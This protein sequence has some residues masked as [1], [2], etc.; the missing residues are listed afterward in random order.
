[1]PKA[2]SEEFEDQMG[3]VL[4]YF[5]NKWCL[6]FSCSFFWIQF[7]NFIRNLHVSSFVI[8]KLPINSSG[9]VYQLHSDLVQSFGSN[10]IA[11]FWWVSLLFNMVYYSTRISAIYDNGD[12]EWTFNVHK[13]VEE[14][15]KR[16]T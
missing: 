5:I 10:N 12:F 1:M 11:L 2:L 15:S 14:V 9:G 3:T 13:N 16:K 8:F 6:D 4:W 7:E